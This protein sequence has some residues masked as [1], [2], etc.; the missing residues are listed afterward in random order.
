LLVA[1]WFLVWQVNAKKTPSRSG[2]AA[3]AAAAATEVAFALSVCVSMW[4][5]KLWQSEKL[6]VSIR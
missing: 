4:L 1:G 2:N 6:A 3:A 5:E